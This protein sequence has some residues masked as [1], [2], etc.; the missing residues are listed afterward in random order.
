MN[1][2][3][4]NASTMRRALKIILPMLIVVLLGVSAFSCWS[5][6]QLIQT[7]RYQTHSLAIQAKLNNLNN[8]IQDAEKAGQANLLLG[9]EDYRQE[10]S[11]TVQHIPQR[12]RELK[13]LIRGDGR[14]VETFGQIDG[15]VMQRLQ[16]LEDQFEAES[17]SREEIEDTLRSYKKGLVLT[18][19]IEKGFQEMDLRESIE[20]NN[21]ERKVKVYSE[22]AIQ[23]IAIG[24]VLTIA[25]IL[26]FA[27]LAQNEIRRRN[28]LL[29]N[30]SQAREGATVASK[31]KSQFLA[32]VSHEI[33][34]PL[35]G[36]IGFSDLLT[37]RGQD[38]EVKRMAGLIH[39]S[40]VSLLKIVNDILDFSKIEAGKMDF[41]IS[42]F[43]IV[44]LVSSVAEL[45][46]L[47][48][49]Q[50]GLTILSYVDGQIP[51]T[52]RGDASRISQVLQNLLSNAVKFTETDG[53]LISVVPQIGAFE[54][55]L[56]VRFEIQ[57]TGVGIPFEGQKLLFQPFNQLNRT[58][59][60][61][62]GLSIS[63]N[64]VEQMNGEIGF[65]SS[66]QR[67]TVFWFE[68]PLPISS[69]TVISKQKPILAKEQT[70]P[71]KLLS[72]S[73]TLRSGLS[74]YFAEW[75]LDM[76]YLPDDSVDVASDQQL[77]IRDGTKW[78]LS[79]LQDEMAKPHSPPTIFLVSTWIEAQ[80]LS[81][82]PGR[83]LL[84]VPFSRDQLLGALDRSM[85]TDEASQIQAETKTSAPPL[86][87]LR[88]P[89]LNG[90]RGLILI[91]EDNAVN[92]ALAEMQ[93]VE[94]GYRAHAVN[95]GKEALNAIEKIHYDL[96]L[97]DVQ[98]P[99][100]D[101]IEAT[102]QIRHLELK[103]GKHLRIIAVTANAVTGDRERCLAAGMD[104]Y[105]AKPFQRS[106]LERVLGQNPAPPPAQAQTL[107]P[108]VLDDLLN[109]TNSRMVKR[110]VETF[111]AT[112]AK[113]FPII[114]S[115]IEARDL[116]RIRFQ[117]HQLKS[118]SLSL[119]ARPL[120][121]LCAEIESAIEA[122]SVEEAE[123]LRKAQAL[124]SEIQRVQ[125]ELAKR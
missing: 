66:P 62:L 54:G 45:F 64:L 115:A 58:E 14:Q 79:Q 122:S 74:A 23:L 2:H 39:Q 81:E 110:L 70:R 38:P 37:N 6:Y 116:D 94:L 120:A 88:G 99:E 29:E 46:S 30:L 55:E 83:H 35:N 41:E 56:R 34:T 97:M 31:L 28:R 11:W 92:Q 71:V 51:T 60:T 7:I 16:Q 33:R 95:N 87:N 85:R 50:K 13:L 111:M 75:G 108:Y 117:A 47:R 91:V 104:D 8:L 32:T 76:E 100:M 107:D 5:I 57:D 69:D 121:A 109:K 15:L 118:S 19:L 113:S 112:L 125:T 24:T 63:K 36:I 10:Y 98:M 3:W 65:D 9:D 61:G 12:L 26:L 20:L 18:R 42:D 77:I 86:M 119:G 73:H 67:G 43:S 124:L 17:A 22:S 25:L 27:F 102:K 68:L 84:T 106:D 53:V 1:N 90:N 59:G 48:A 96:V 82:L 114:E 44:Q 21:H 103:S 101:G 52:L 78:S 105:I 123:V 4:Q 72:K 89:H 93:I 49:R 80:N 40:G